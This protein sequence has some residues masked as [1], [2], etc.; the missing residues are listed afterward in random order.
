MRLR[1]AWLAGLLAALPA[2]GQ[3]PSPAL[4]NLVTLSAQA[5][6]EVPNDTLLAT[7]AA[8]AEGADPAPLAEGVNRSM[9]RALELARAYPSVKARSGNYQTYPVYD[10]NRIARWRVRQELR[11]EA[12]DFGAAT[13]LIGKLQSIL[14]VAQ[15]AH[16]VSG[17]AR[18]Q[19][20]NTLL[21]EA[22]AAF[23]ERARLAR[24]ALKAKGYRLRDLNLSGGGP[25]PPR[26][27]AM[28]AMAAE[29]AAPALEAG[30][31]RIAV[32]VTGTVQLQ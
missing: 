22:I 6:R 17:E 29:A 14:T 2:Q 32:T 21:A 13:E 12:S 5:E 23:E 18:R 31:T 26:P 27:L 9:R 4:F 7:L 20:E 10:K 28:R 30:A 25:M 15:L 19:A 8:E 1:A 24:D 3:E 16:G 11:L